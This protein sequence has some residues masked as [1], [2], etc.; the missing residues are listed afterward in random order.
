MGVTVTADGRASTSEEADSR[1]PQIVR[2]LLTFVRIALGGVWIY[3]GLVK[4]TDIDQTNLTIRAFDI[5]PIGWAKPMS[6]GLPAVEI[7]LGLLLVVGLAVRWMAA[8]SALFLLLYIGAIA[9]AAARGLR[10]DCGC[11]SQGGQ[12]DANTSTRY[13]LDILRDAGLFLLSG[14]LVWR[15]RTYFSLD[16]WLR[17]PDTGAAESLDA[18]ADAD[19]T[20]ND[21]RRLDAGPDAT[22]ASQRFAADEQGGDQAVTPTTR[23][24]D[25]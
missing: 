16:G 23:S 8:V 1:W 24:R 2:G 15:P 21:R 13:T 19:D 6:Y 22:R 7:A 12:L 10:I 4:I 11:F 17:V 20:A 9:S 5:V 3:A 25:Q 14:L 18:A